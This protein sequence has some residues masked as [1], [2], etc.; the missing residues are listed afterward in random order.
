MA[1]KQ[2]HKTEYRKMEWQKQE[3]DADCSDV[4]GSSEMPCPV[5][6][7]HE[8]YP[9]HRAVKDVEFSLEFLQQLRAEGTVK[10]LDVA[11]IARLVTMFRRRLN[12]ALEAATSSQLPTTVSAESEDPPTEQRGPSLASAG[13]FVDRDERA[14]RFAYVT[15][16]RDRRSDTGEGRSSDPGKSSSLE[17]S[18][19]RKAK[20]KKSR[21]SDSAGMSPK[22][23]PELKN[24]KKSNKKTKKKK[25]KSSDSGVHSPKN[26]P[27]P[28]NTSKHRKTRK[29]K[30]PAN[31]FKEKAKEYVINLLNGT[32]DEDED[33]DHA[34]IREM[35]SELLEVDPDYPIAEELEEFSAKFMQ[36]LY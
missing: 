36:K 35:I 17:R 34:R 1:T 33:P 18:S 31:E 6:P 9:L 16:G 14:V 29:T 5:D 26:R 11:R 20:E 15:P 28:T 30:E 12:S 13:K 2:K 27:E 8:N 3:Y 32:E 21:S 24:Q 10:P 22:K 7:G 19:A 25:E 4:E 23:R